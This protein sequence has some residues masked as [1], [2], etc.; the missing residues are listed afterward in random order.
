MKF[1]DF[2]SVMQQKGLRVVGQAAYGLVGNYPVSAQLNNGKSGNMVQISFALR[3]DQAKEHSKALQKTCREGMKKVG[4]AMAGSEALVISLPAKKADLDSRYDTMTQVVLPAMQEYGI[5]P[6]DTCP[7][8]HQTGCDCYA[9]VSGHYRAVHRSCLN[10]VRDKVGADIERNE[11]QGNYA[12]GIVGALLGGIIAAVPTILTIWFLERIYSLLYALI[13]LGAYF[14]YQKL[15]GKMNRVSVVVTCVLSIL[16]GVL[17]DPVVIAISLAQ[18][19]IPLSLMPMLFKDDEFMRLMAPEMVKSLLF[20]ALGIFIVWSKISRT[21][22][23]QAQSVEQMMETVQA[24]PGSV[25]QNQE[26]NAQ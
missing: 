10:Q 4:G 16:I 8:C 26:Q 11:K 17:I 1:Q 9:A 5:L 14:G 24:I 18:E 3:P 19:G 15:G 12:L 25:V 20:V 13:P 6:P 22:G 2:S 23:H 21:S 7:V